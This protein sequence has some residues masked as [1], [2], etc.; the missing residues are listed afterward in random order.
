MNTFIGFIMG[1]MVWISI[2]IFIFG[3]AFKVVKI[4]NEVKAKEAYILNY[5]NLK[6]SLRSI[7]A[8]LVPFLPRSTRLH[9]VFW[10]VSYVFHICIF[11]VPLFLSS[12]IVLI[13]ESFGIVWPALNDAVADG[14]TVVVIAALVFFFLRRVLVREIK[15]LTAPKDYILLALVAIPFI[16]GFLAYHQWIAYRW[17]VIIHVL[18]S[19]LILMLIP[20]SGLVH[21]ITAPLSRA[22]TGSEFGGIRHA[23]DW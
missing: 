9:P 13:N 15:Y 22:Y 8:W 10:G 11:L 20:F 23:K 19:E 7:G 1:P 12:H 3:L 17:M 21:M 2:L 4:I 18:S 6:Y 16:T 14:L 5:M